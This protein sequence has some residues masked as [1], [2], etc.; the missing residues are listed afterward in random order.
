MGFWVVAQAGAERLGEADEGD[1]VVPAGVAAAFEVVESEAVFEFAVVVFDAPADLGQADQVAQGGVGGQVGQPVVGGFR[2]AGWPFGQQPA[3]GQVPSGVR[4]MSRLAGR[5]RSARN[6][7]R[8]AA[9]GLRGVL[10]VPCR[11]VTTLPVRRPAV[12]TRVFR[13]PGASR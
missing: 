11:Q 5:T 12:M 13:L 4:G 9:V 8:I 6:R 3:F 7:E 2:L 10:R 1:V